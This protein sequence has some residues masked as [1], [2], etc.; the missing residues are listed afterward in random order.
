MR[1]FELRIKTVTPLI[2]GG[3]NNKEFELR[4]IEIAG[5][6]RYWYRK[7]YGT[8]KETDI[9][10]ST[11]RKGRFKLRVSDVEG[12]R[13]SVEDYKRDGKKNTDVNHGRNYFLGLMRERK[14]LK[15]NSE[16]TLSVVVY[17]D[18][19]E[20]IKKILGSLWASIYLGGWGA[21]S[22]RGL[23][24][25]K[26]VSAKG[27]FEGIKAFVK[28]DFEGISKI[29][30]FKSSPEIYVCEEFRS[31]VY[32]KEVDATTKHMEDGKFRK[33]VKRSKNQNIKVPCENSMKCLD[34]MGL[35]FLYFRSYLEPDYST[36][37]SYVKEMKSKKS[38]RKEI[39]SNKV[40]RSSF[41]LPLPFYFSSTKSRISVP[42]RSPSRIFVRVYEKNGKFYPAV[43]FDNKR[44]NPHGKDP[45]LAVLYVKALEKS[46]FKKVI[47]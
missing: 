7:I 15:E 2:M 30:G 10:G 24:S 37:K 16:F 41:G 17:D 9:F 11:K 39:E 28:E 45:D 14:A 19:N 8:E 20:K 32:K 38:Y 42:G 18:D 26:V 34:L 43:V 35:T 12:K 1:S 25:L 3:A 22:R 31:N 5:I 23:G 46:G 33:E 4:E 6:M 44:R 13:A 29:F 27:D 36:V 40:Q 47:L 21:R